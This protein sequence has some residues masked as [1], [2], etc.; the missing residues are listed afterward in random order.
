[1][2]WRKVGRWAE[3]P[4]GQGVRRLVDGFALAIF[5]VDDTPYVIEDTCSHEEASLADG[6]LEG[7]QVVCPLHGARFDLATGRALSLPAVTGVQAFPAEI[8]D[9]ELWVKLDF[10]SGA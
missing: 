1:M 8:R 5:R 2:G 9:G 3:I 6:R 10:E 4:S 7:R